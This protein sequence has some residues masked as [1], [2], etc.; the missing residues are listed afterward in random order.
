M[1]RVLRNSRTMVQ[2]TPVALVGGDREALRAYQELAV[3]VRKGIRHWS[4]VLGTGA[5]PEDGRVLAV[6]EHDTLVMVYRHAETAPSKMG[7]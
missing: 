1:R 6:V 7:T 5:E 4:Q 3:D 2:R